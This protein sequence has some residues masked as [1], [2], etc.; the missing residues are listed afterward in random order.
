MPRLVRVRNATRETDLGDRIEVADRFWKRLR[1]LLGRRAPRDGEGL[2][3]RPSRGVHMYGMRY[4]LDVLL[5]DD[6]GRIVASYRELR[7][8]KRTRL[9]ADATQA[10][11]LRAGTLEKSST[12][13]G[14]ILTWSEAP[15]G[16][17]E[18]TGARPDDNHETRRPGRTRF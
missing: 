7:P 12:R 9:H 11:E 8:G 1:G 10:L 2:L 16:R 3:I 17:T 14:D 6:A 13:T 4:P 18:D 5:L 15:A